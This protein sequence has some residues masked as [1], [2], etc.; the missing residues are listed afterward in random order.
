[1]KVSAKEKHDFQLEI[2]GNYEWIISILFNPPSLFYL[3]SIL[4][5]HLIFMVSV[6]VAVTFDEQIS[7]SCYHLIGHLI[8]YIENIII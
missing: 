7:Y 1:M 4:V 5:F 2:L 3:Q 6:A 8:S